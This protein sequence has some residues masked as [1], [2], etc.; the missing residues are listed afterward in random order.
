MT[1]DAGPIRILSADDHPVL[2]QGIAGLVAVQPGMTLVAAAA[3]GWEA[4]FQFRARHP[5][6]TLTDLHVQAGKKSLSPEVSCQLAEPK[7]KLRMPVS[8]SWL[9]LLW[10]DRPR[11]P[12]ISE[13]A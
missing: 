11:L 2:R 10:L 9:V 3:H 8:A 4:I 6:V 5:D 13:T 12:A 7:Q 1:S